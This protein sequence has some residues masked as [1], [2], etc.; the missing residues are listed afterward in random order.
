VCVCVCVCVY[1]QPVCLAEGP[2]QHL[3][4][5]HTHTHTHTHTDRSCIVSH[6]KS[7]SVC[8]C[9]CV[10]TSLSRPCNSLNTHTVT[11]GQRDSVTEAEMHLSLNGWWWWWHDL[12]RT[13]LWTFGFCCSVEGKK[14]KTTQEW[15]NTW[16]AIRASIRSTSHRT[17]SNYTMAFGE[18][19]L[20]GRGG[21]GYCT[22]VC[23]YMNAPPPTSTRM[24]FWTW[25]NRPYG[26]LRLLS[27]A[28]FFFYFYLFVHSFKPGAV[29]CGMTELV[30]EVA[31]R[32]PWQK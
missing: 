26:V 21:R 24:G 31:R 11:D 30:A 20:V 32:R 10:H 2:A 23:A 3:A 18:A 6:T 19:Y 25:E 13:F 5:T 22:H 28:G 15:G 16:E 8:V 12:E 1:C 29:E 4:Y 27:H 9:V 17:S 14:T 7:L